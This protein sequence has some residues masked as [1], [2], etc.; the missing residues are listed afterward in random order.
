MKKTVMPD[1]GKPDDAT[2]EAWGHNIA[3]AEAIN[4]IM[5]LD[6]ETAFFAIEAH[7]DSNGNVIDVSNF[8][9]IA[10]KAAAIW[11]LKNII[12]GLE[13]KHYEVAFS[14]PNKKVQ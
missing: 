9:N 5:N 1:W 12:S 3:M 8:T 10:N 2:E 11:L 13:D 14:D 6:G 7:I 4:T